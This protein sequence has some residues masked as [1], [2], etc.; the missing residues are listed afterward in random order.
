MKKLRDI[1]R[2]YV[3][4]TE[5][6]WKALPIERQVLLTKAFFA[7]YVLLTVMIVINVFLS[8]GQKNNYMSIDHI[9]GISLKSGKEGLKQNDTINKPL[10]K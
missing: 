5:N 10:K 4:K 3:L 6:D 8:K 2:Q 1:V 9:G 7:G